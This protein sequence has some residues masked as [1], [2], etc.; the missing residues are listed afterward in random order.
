[1]LNAVTDK[2]LEVITELLTALFKL[3]LEPFM[4]L[5]SIKD[6]VFGVEG[7]Q[8][9]IYGIFTTNEINDIY[10]PGFNLMLILAGFFI[11][12]GVVMYGNRIASSGINASNRIFVMEFFRDWILV[13]LLLF[14]L[15]ILY[16]VIFQFNHFIVSLFGDAYNGKLASLDKELKPDDP[17]LL[18]K[19]IIQFVLLGLSL[20]ASF[21]YLMRK[22]TLMI[23]MILGPL[24]VSFLLM[25][26]TRR[27]TF[28]WLKEMIGTIFVQSIHAFLFWVVAKMAGAYGGIIGGAAEEGSKL[29]ESVILY[30]IFIPVSE[31]LRSLLG[32]G[33]GLHNSWSK[34]GAMFGLS[35]L[36][37]VY[38]SIKGA[39]GDKSVMSALKGAYE[40][41]RKR[42]E[43]ENEDDNKIGANTG[44]FTGTTPSAERMLKA[45]DFISKAGRAVGGVAGSLIG[46]PMGPYGSISMATIGAELGDTAGELTGRFGMAAAEGLV[47][48]AKTF[49]KSFAEGF[50]KG[51]NL[52]AKS[53]ELLTDI[54][55]NSDLI[56]DVGPK[57]YQEFRNQMK[58]RFPDIGERELQTQ[59]GQLLETRREAAMRLIDLAKNDQTLAN[60]DALKEAAVNEMMSRFEKNNKAAFMEQ[61]NKE[62]PLPATATDAQRLEHQAKANEAWQALLSE[63]RKG[64]EDIANDVIKTLSHDIPHSFI[65]KDEFAQQFASKALDFDKERYSQIFNQ[66]EAAFTQKN[67]DIRTYSNAVSRAVSKVPSGKIYDHRS[68]NRDYLAQS[69]AYAR[70]AQQK[71]AYIQSQ[72]DNGV[73]RESALE[74]WKSIEGEIYKKNLQEVVQAMPSQEAFHAVKAH[75]MN[76][77]SFISGVSGVAY[78][79]LNAVME[80]S[81]IARVVRMAKETKLGH[82][83]SVGVTSAYANASMAFSNTEGNLFQ[84]TAAAI[85]EGY[86]Q[87]KQDVAVAAQTPYVTPHAVEKQALIRNMAGYAGGLIGGIGG[88]KKFSQMAEKISPLNKAVNQ[89]VYEASEIYQMAQKTTD[90]NGNVVVAKGAVRLV[91]TANESYIEVK[92]QIGATHVVSRIGRGDS[93]LAS[94][95][96]VYTDLTVTEQGISVERSNP[97]A[98]KMDSGGNRQ[99]INR[100][101]KIDPNQLLSNRA[102]KPYQER[103][104]I[105]AYNQM[106]EYKQ[107]YLND[108]LNAKLKNIRA[109]VERDRS[110]VI[111]QTPQGETV[112][113]SPYGQG[114]TRLKDNEVVTM[115]YEIRNQ[116]FIQQKIKMEV[117]GKEVKQHDYTS[118]F[119]IDEYVPHRPNKRLLLRRELDRIR[120]PQGVK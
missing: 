64:Y 74:N 76:N 110:Y 46:S 14:N 19:M 79:S 52:N 3:I 30:V 26:W 47:N 40:G 57:T 83:V 98:Y 93:S 89:Q 92:D 5:K 27:I 22:L 2:I 9:L 50:T 114:D 31:G 32:L 59:W 53:D 43:V 81:G 25:P 73:T 80:T 108:V 28:S 4:D 119:E 49:G 17:A 66:G 34:V 21:Y 86:Q 41:F 56:D 11:L 48:R 113:I 33:G 16:D 91:T 1:M 18:G 94:N 38:G 104:N 87:A 72:L 78:G 71:D 67:G 96:V 103:P 8:N 118:T 85:T 70:T 62:N 24:M 105:P 69:I 58:E 29:I 65:K 6:W 112:R 36:A 116:R 82:L 102:S 111:A 88:Y 115:D 117:N 44:T 39:I 63:Q 109:I 42:K 101:M 95:E 77:S 12:I 51:K 20:W 35:G 107:F 97:Y 90:S 99:Y 54:I 13:S 75:A 61:F 10:K 55:A 100:V 45:G 15:D 120:S 106:V 68:V 37:G 84:K 23:F 7:D 60:A